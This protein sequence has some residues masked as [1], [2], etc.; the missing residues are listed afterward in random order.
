MQQQGF[1]VL[2]YNRETPILAKCVHCSLKFFAPDPL[3]HKPIQ[4]KEYLLE[5]F[6]AHEL[7]SYRPNNAL[8]SILDL[9]REATGLQEIKRTNGPVGKLWFPFVLSC[10]RWGL[11]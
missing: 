5:K 7:Q 2:K 1:V 11:H 4:A 9:L 10:S 8:S 3:M 6:W